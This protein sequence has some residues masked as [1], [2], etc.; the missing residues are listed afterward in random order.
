MYSGRAVCSK[1][2][3]PGHKDQTMPRQLMASFRYSVCCCTLLGPRCKKNS[4]IH[5]YM[6]AATHI[7]LYILEQQSSFLKH[8]ANTSFM[9]SFRA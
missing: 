6:T 2:G 1:E 3:A 8:L 5:D 4:M 9:A 7:L